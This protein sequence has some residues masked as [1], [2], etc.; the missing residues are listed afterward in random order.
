MNTIGDGLQEV[1]NS[2]PLDTL[3]GVRVVANMV[4]K[5]AGDAVHY[6]GVAIQS[7]DAGAAT[8]EGNEHIIDPEHQDF[9]AANEDM[10]NGDLDVREAR[11]REVAIGEIATQGAAAASQI[12]QEMTDKKSEV[13]NRLLVC[14][15]ALGI[16]STMRS[17][18]SPS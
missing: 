18:I 1:S 3:R 15:E 16:I 13:T 14:Q 2:L 11:L 10:A 9:E 17:L 4:N 8:L 5:E 12:G 6:A 7:I